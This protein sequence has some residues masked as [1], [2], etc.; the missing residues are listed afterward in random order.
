MIV[1]LFTVGLFAS[2]LLITLGFVEDQHAIK[3]EASLKAEASELAEAEV[4]AERIRQSVATYEVRLKGDSE[5]LR[6]TVSIGLAAT[7]PDVTIEQLM[8]HADR[9]LY[10]A[11]QAD[12]D[13]IRVV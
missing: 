2:L 13:C 6:F 1:N 9:A 7:G 3:V 10:R 5:P 11:R 12:R 4:I 8:S